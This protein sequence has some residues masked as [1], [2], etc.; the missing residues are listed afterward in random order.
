MQRFRGQITMFHEQLIFLP[1]QNGPEWDVVTYINGRTVI[2]QAGR[3]V[4]NGSEQ[5]HLREP[6][7][8]DYIDF[9]PVH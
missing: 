6:I 7:L 1:N 2:V 9:D 4:A 8:T 3:A 5:V